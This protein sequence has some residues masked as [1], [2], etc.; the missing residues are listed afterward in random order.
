MLLRCFQHTFSH[1]HLLHE[2]CFARNPKPT[3]LQQV[4]WAHGCSSE[5]ELQQHPHL[6]ALLLALQMA[7]PDCSEVSITA[8]TFVAPPWLEGWCHKWVGGQR[9]VTLLVVQAYGS[10]PAPLRASAVSVCASQSPPACK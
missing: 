4:A 1:L 9:S 5:A 3:A 7:C 10:V 2:R 6:A 8:L